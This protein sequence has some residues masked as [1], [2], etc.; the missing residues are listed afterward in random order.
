MVTVTSIPTSR[1]NAKYPASGGKQFESVVKQIHTSTKE[2][3]CQTIILKKLTMPQQHMKPNSQ[4]PKRT[5]P[6]PK[7]QAPSTMTNAIR[8]SLT[9]ARPV[10]GDITINLTEANDDATL[11]EFAHFMEYVL[12]TDKE[13]WKIIINNFGCYMQCL[14]N[15][16]DDASHI[17]SVFKAI[18]EYN[19]M[20]YLKY[21][22]ESLA[23]PNVE[24][25]F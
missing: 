22:Q 14:K 4:S 2:E 11:I 9:F 18:K 19:Y 7:P 6:R 17:M 5:A 10:Y 3:Y 13:E 21:K 24:E 16:G 20:D 15:Q 1:Q 12:N 23:D 25:V 8:Q